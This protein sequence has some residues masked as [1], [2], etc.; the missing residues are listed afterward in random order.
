MN[1]LIDARDSLEEGGGENRA[2]EASETEPQV[3][4]AA[5]RA[6]DRAEMPSPGPLD[7]G[8]Q[9]RGTRERAAAPRAPGALVLNS[10]S[11]PG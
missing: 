4:S 6:R 11:K 9:P 8:M 2:A 3:K 10:V 7:P 5:A 1:D